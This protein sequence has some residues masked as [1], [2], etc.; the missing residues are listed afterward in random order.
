VETLRS[1]VGSFTNNFKDN[2]AI[3]GVALPKG[4]TIISATAAVEAEEDP[5]EL[6]DEDDIEFDVTEEPH[7]VVPTPPADKGGMSGS[8]IMIVVFN[9][10]LALAIVSFFVQKRCSTS[11]AKMPSKATP[12]PS[13]PE[14]KL[15]SPTSEYLLDVVDEPSPTAMA[16]VVI[17]PRNPQPPKPVVSPRTSSIPLIPATQAPLDLDEVSRIPSV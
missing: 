7:R 13:S 1:D 11:G 14:G 4:L 10:M 9:A 16:E 17:E 8:T 6:I 5:A 2:A 12:M 15:P 3:G